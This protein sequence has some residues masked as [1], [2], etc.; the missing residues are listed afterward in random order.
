MTI[1]VVDDEPDVQPL[2]EQKFRKERKAG[3]LDFHFAFSGEAA[4]D[5]VQDQ[6]GVDLVLI[7]ADINMPG[8]SGLELL[9]RIKARFAHLTIYMITA[10][11]DEN[12]YQQ[13]M[14][15]GADDY[16]TKPIDFD[17]LKNKIANL[18]GKAQ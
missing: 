18:Y 17:E 10:Y 6:G 11:G 15:Y 16:I 14:A 2:F 8:M 13:A 4:L 1:L 3:V 9:K 5:Y 7:L 12:N